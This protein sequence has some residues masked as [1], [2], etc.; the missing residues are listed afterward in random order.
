M[1]CIVCAAEL[2]NDDVGYHKKLVNRGET[3]N[4]RCIKC[5]C[6]YYSLSLEYAYQMIEHFKKQGCTL[7]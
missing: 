6:E 7:F 1:K 2:T 5:N 3:E 4:F